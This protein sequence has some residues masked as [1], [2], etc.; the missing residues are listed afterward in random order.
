MLVLLHL[1]AINPRDLEL[2]FSQGVTWTDIRILIF[3]AM[4]RVIFGLRKRRRWMVIR[5]WTWNGR[6]VCVQR[7]RW[8]YFGGVA[9][10]ADYSGWYCD[11]FGGGGGMSKFL[12]KD[13]GH[14]CTSFMWI[15]SQGPWLQIDLFQSPFVCSEKWI[16]CCSA[17]VHCSTIRDNNMMRI[18]GLAKRKRDIIHDKMVMHWS[19]VSFTLRYVPIVM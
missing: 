15:I 14:K 2:N 9:L 8:C 18:D 16:V 5:I 3:M 17:W 7:K 19:Q 6:R 10:F 12:V 4:L 13:W 11:P 1:I